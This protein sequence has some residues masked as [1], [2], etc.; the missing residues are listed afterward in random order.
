MTFS[1]ALRRSATGLALAA[2]LGGCASSDKEKSSGED[3]QRLYADA[4]DELSSNNY[5]QA[6]KALEKLEARATGTLL[7]QQALLELAHAHWRA[8]ERV[9][10]LATLDRFAKLHPSS[11]ASDYALYLRGLVN[12]NDNLGL[13]GGLARQNLSERDQQASRA[14]Y[15][16]FS[17]LVQRYPESKYAADARLR[18]DFIVN[19][20]AEYEVHVARYYLR[21]GAHLAAANRAQ[22]AV[23]DYDGAPA[24]EEA[25]AIMVQSYERLGLNSLRD[26]ARR[27]L[28]KN[29]PASR[30]LDAATPTATPAA[31]AD[32]PARPWWRFW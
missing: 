20:L 3:L 26:D 7:G 30:F 19:S 22:Q 11:P 31:S 15:Q 5:E 12:F 16:A 1:E 6:I 23:T 14:A 18:M 13:L 29:F 4:R 10:A 28:Q 32:V 17:Q 25:L 27:V 9:L 21:R 24:A 2:L 8:G